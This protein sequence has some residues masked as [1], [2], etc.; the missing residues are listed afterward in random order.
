MAVTDVYA[1]DPEVKGG[2]DRA[3]MC[4]N[5]IAFPGIGQFK[6]TPVGTHRIVAW[7]NAGRIRT[8][9][10]TKCVRMIHIN[11][12]AVTFDLPVGRY[13][14]VVPT[15]GV[16]VFAEKVRGPLFR[17]GRVMEFPGAVEA[18]VPGRSRAIPSAGAFDGLEAKKIGTGVEFVA[19]N[20]RRVFPIHRGWGFLS[21]EDG[22]AGQQPQKTES[23]DGTK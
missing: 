14:D 6:R 10:K 8:L 9:V 20:D 18:E 3:E 5:P 16:E 17:S 23:D 7:R 12:R 21:S 22:M 1:I 11:R 19:A 15:A 4:D 2:F 13:R